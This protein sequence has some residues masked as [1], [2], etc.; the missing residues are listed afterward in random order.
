LS[1]AAAHG[2]ALIGG[3]AEQTTD[4]VEMLSA[5]PPLAEVL[6]YGKARATDTGQLGALFERIAVQGALALDHA[7]RGLEP[8]EAEKLGEVVQG[9]DGAI[10]LID[11]DEA[12]LQPWWRALQ[13]LLDT[14]L[15]SRHVA[16]RAGRLL[17]EAEKLSA[18]EAVTLMTRMLSPGTPVADAAAFFAGFLEGASLRLVH[19]EGLRGAVDA[20]LSGLPEEDFIEY[21]PLFRRVFSG[22]DRSERKRLLDA[23]LGRGGAALTGLRRVPDAEAHWPGH[24]ERVLSFMRAGAAA[25]GARD[26]G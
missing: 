14:P 11:Q 17:Y 24:M 15:A 2:V 6:R 13:R 8:S 19:D 16:G 26:D 5:L 4:C 9:A 7:A 12:L 20:W 3:R 18:E 21:L 23:V 25:G 22:I 10:R 1:A